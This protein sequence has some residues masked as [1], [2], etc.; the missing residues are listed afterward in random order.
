MAN[1]YENNMKRM[2]TD[3]FI[4]K[5]WLVYRNDL[6]TNFTTKFQ[7][8]R[9]QQI[10]LGLFGASDDYTGA[11]HTLSA[12]S[13]SK[14]DALMQSMTIESSFVTPDLL[15]KWYEDLIQ[16]GDLFKRQNFC[17]C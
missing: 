15:L 11:N 10:P 4:M 2:L 12:E 6:I 17:R 9:C 3:Q 13:N 8:S 14:W 5:F 16:L 1:P 7:C